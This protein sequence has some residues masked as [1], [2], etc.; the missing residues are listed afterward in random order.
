MTAPLPDRESKAP[1]SAASQAARGWGPRHLV[2]LEALAPPSLV[3]DERGRVVHLSPKAGDF[4]RVPG[5]EPTRDLFDM[6]QPALAEPLRKLW[7]QVTGTR[8]EAS[9]SL[10]GAAAECGAAALRIVPLEDGGQRWYVVAFEAR[11]TGPRETPG[12]DLRDVLLRHVIES[13]QDFAIFS[14]D[15]D[16][17]VTS[18]NSG[19][20]RLLGYSEAEMLGQPGDVIFTNLDRQSGAPETEARTALAEGRATDDRVHVRKDGTVFWAEGV[21]MPMRDASGQPAGFVKILRDQTAEREARRRLERSQAELMQALAETQKARQELEAADAAKDRFLAVLSHELR[22]PLASIASASELLLMPKL[23]E[24]ALEKAALVVQR[25]ARAMK[26]LL[27]ELLDVSRLT[28]GRLTL[29]RR[30]VSI[31]EV[32]QSALE[33]ARPLVQTAGHELVVSLPPRSAEVDGDPMRLAQVVSNLVGNAA[34]Y[35]PDSGRIVVSAEVFHDEVVISVEDNGIGMEPAQIDHMFDLFSQGDRPQGRSNEGLGIGLALARNIVELHGG[36]IMASSGGPGQGSQLRVGLPLLRVNDEEEPPL[37]EPPMRAPEAA[38]AAEG[39]LVLVADDNGDAAW[40]LAKLL[41]LS[42]F[43]AITARSGEEALA[44]AD[45]HRPAIA[46]LDIGMPDLSGHE[47]ARRLREE[48]WGRDMILVAATGW[49]QETDIR[50]S[51]EAGFDAHLTK[52]LNVGRIKGVIEE[53]AARR[54]R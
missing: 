31:A 11:A 13:A 47:V 19:A 12:G 2:L 30:P 41:E 6:V 51:M 7:R 20:E 34:K 36:W 9:V 44:M 23:P 28:L 15:L 48:D 54:R 5:G 14:L 27:D 38:Q 46:L 37:E 21:S 26:V 4:L 35:T 17:N 1:R 33:T 50:H 29:T 45:Q 22:N 39:E 25:Q 40:G 3:A 49:G 52:P 24:A 16:R 42:G 32:V 53:L 10:D 18:W 8:R 43:R